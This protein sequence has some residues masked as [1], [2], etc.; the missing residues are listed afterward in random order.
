MIRDQKWAVVPDTDATGVPIKGGGLQIPDAITGF[1][2]GTLI[3][4]RNDCPIINI[5]NPVSG[6]NTIHDGARSGLPDDIR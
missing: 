5:Q 6:C 2:F 1:T 3:A 4:S